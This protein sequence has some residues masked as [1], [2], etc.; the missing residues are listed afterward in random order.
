MDRRG[1]LTYERLSNSLERIQGAAKVQFSEPKDRERAQD[2]QRVIND[3][4]AAARA[5]M[6]GAAM[7]PPVQ[8]KREVEA[9]IVEVHERWNEVCEQREYA[10]EGVQKIH[11]IGS[12]SLNGVEASMGASLRKT[13]APGRTARSPESGKENVTPPAAY[14]PQD[15]AK[16]ISA[17]KKTLITKRA[18]TKKPSS[19][20][21]VKKRPLTRTIRSKSTAPPIPTATLLSADD[22]ECRA[23]AAALLGLSE[24]SSSTPFLTAAPSSTSVLIPPIY[25]KK[26]T[27]AVYAEAPQ[28]PCSPNQF[29]PSSSPAP[30]RRL[31]APAAYAPVPQLEPR[32]GAQRAF[33]LGVEYAV[34]HL[35]PCGGEDEERGVGLKMWVESQVE[36]QDSSELEGAREGRYGSHNQ[37][38]ESAQVGKGIVAGR[39]FWDVV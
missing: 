23:A 16:K 11:K 27:H 31:I 13:S 29:H 21:G 9:R 39:G 34:Q 18:T 14:A 30:K 26:H 19:T 15:T 10:A 38:C 4:L 20:A 33:V 35:C 22:A 37:G 7:A 24:Q 25:G 2:L 1:R 12:S 3:A 28:S 32:I 8:L 5:G 36:Q 17:V 6:S